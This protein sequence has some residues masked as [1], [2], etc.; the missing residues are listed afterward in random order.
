MPKKIDYVVYGWP[1]SWLGQTTTVR[2]ALKNAFSL[3]LLLLL[4]YRKLIKLTM[5]PPST[6]VGWEVLFSENAFRPVNETYSKFTMAC[7]WFVFLIDLRTT[8]LSICRNWNWTGSEQEVNRNWI[9]CNVVPS[10][11]FFRISRLHNL[12][13]N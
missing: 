7:I 3:V 10:N 6:V 2:S 9:A 13:T 11:I 8:Y 12:T 1:L 5:S 4:L